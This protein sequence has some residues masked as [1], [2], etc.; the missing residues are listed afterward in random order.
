MKQRTLKKLILNASDAETFPYISMGIGSGSYSD[1]EFPSFSLE[2]GGEVEYL[3]GTYFYLGSNEMLPLSGVFFGYYPVDDMVGNFQLISEVT[4]FAALIDFYGY[5]MTTH[6]R[7]SLGYELEGV[8]SIY[9]SWADNLYYEE[10]RKGTPFSQIAH[11]LGEGYAQRYMRPYAV[12][13]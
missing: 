4:T 7:D 8:Q 12:V 9:G 11:M 5:Y 1:P 13:Q 6:Y 2:D 10:K 3:N